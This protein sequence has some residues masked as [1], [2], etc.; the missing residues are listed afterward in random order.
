[1]LEKSLHSVYNQFRKIFMGEG[2][3]DKKIKFE[4]NKKQLPEVE[5]KVINAL[6]NRKYKWRT[7]KGI[8]AETTLDLS[9]VE[10]ALHHLKD[11]ELII[12]ASKPT[13]NGD[14]LYTSSGRYMFDK[15]YRINRWL[16]VL[17]DEIK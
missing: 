15:E 10:S 14:V 8:S 2:I 1:M 7:L 6:E 9:Q 17:S 12:V 13:K 11:N 3:M 5:L 4:L 16:S